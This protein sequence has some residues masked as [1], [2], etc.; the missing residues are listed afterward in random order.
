MSSGGKN[1]DTGPRDEDTPSTANAGGGPIE[2]LT[3]IGSFRIEKVLGRGGMGVVYAAED[4]RLNRRVAIKS[5]PPEI[6]DDP[7][8][9]ARLKREAKILACL[10]HPNIAAIYEEL[11][12]EGKGY[13]V[14]E[15]VPGQTLGEKM[16]HGTIPLK[17]TLSIAV[18]MAEALAAAAAQDVIHR[19]LKPSN[20]KITPDHTVKVLDFGIAKVLPRGAS[21]DDS[22]ITRTGGI[23]GTPTYMSPEQ[24]R[25]DEVDHR[26]DIWSFGCV[27]YEML[28]GSVPFKGRTTSDTLANILAHEPDWQALPPTTPFNIRLLVRRCLEKDLRKRLQHIGDAAIEIRETLNPPEI[29]PPLARPPEGRRRRAAWRL[30]GACA[31]AGLL[32]GL[33]LTVVALKIYSARSPAST[34][35]IGPTR[36]VIDLPADHNLALSRSMPLAVAQRAIAL[37]PDGSNLVY[38]ADLG[39]TT[40]LYLRRMDHLEASPIAGTEGGFAP[41]FSPDS[42][43]VGFFTTDKL[44]TVSLLGGTPTTICDARNPKGACWGHNQMIYFAESEGER[45]SRVPATGGKTEHLAAKTEPPEQGSFPYGH[46]Q[47]LPDGE[48]LL[49]SSMSSTILFS[50]R[51]SIKR[52]LIKGGQHATY[53]PSGHILFARAGAIAAVPFSLTSL[54]PTGPYVPVLDK[55]MLDSR[56]GTAQFAVS[57]QGSLIY[58]PGGDIAQS[59]PLWIDRT[60]NVQALPMPPDNYGTFKL[61]PD[62]KRLV[63]QLNQDALTHIYIYDIAEG[64]RTRLTSQGLN[65]GPIWTPDGRRITFSRYREEARRRD[66]FWKTVDS[67]DPPELLHL[68]ESGLAPFPYSWS[69]DGRLLAFIERTPKTSSDIWILPIDGDRRPQLIAGTEFAE[70][71][72]A[73]SP[74]GRWIAYTSDADGRF[75]VYVRPYPD[76]DR[77]WKISDD[78]GEEP[79]FSPLG[80]ELFYRNGDKWMAVSISSEPEFSAGR[81]QLLF[82]GPYVNVPGISYDVA[83]DGRRFLVLKP[84]YDDSKVD[85][86]HLVL[87][88]FEELKRLA[89]PG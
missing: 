2:Q 41:F 55:V 10:N 36:T 64:S 58:V 14:L 46:P 63:V 29:S 12:K 23:I 30:A 53:V 22:T 72:P 15:Y 79:I 70:W 74:D 19:D 9:V 68:S 45:L 13:L 52:I 50:L 4:T 17:E 61:S 65:F 67:S 62:G 49:L 24:L 42:R 28:T 66:L 81:P 84:A 71:G 43:S 60:G 31:L 40:Q 7:E 11:Q 75:Q 87:N 85:R 34:A 59:I 82:E 21:E 51:D 73:F 83:P 80:N 27:L 89:P 47:L 78:F 88:W 56:H 35:A 54:Q 16:T 20:V 26:C 33:V 39:K 69:P 48:H 3:A 32:A 77:L 57:D 38:V 76:D 6:T 25:G 44:K 86:L 37:S 5:L 1:T 18:Q 8:V